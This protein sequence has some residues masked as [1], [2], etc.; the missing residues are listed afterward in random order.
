MPRYPFQ[1]LLSQNPLW[2]SLPSMVNSL[3]ANPPPNVL[4]Y[5]TACLT[6]GNSRGVKIYPLEL[7]MT[8]LQGIAFIPSK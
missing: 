1:G 4:P 5:F 7:L 3:Q 8:N 2:M 6:D